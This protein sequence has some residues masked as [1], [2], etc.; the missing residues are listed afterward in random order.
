MMQ[1]HPKHNSLSCYA[2]LPID[3]MAKASISLPLIKFNS[4]LLFADYCAL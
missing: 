2:I 3:D 4:A 1:R